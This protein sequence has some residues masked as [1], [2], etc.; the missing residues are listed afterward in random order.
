MVRVVEVVVPLVEG[1]HAIVW[2]SAQ[3]LHFE[4][5]LVHEDHV[6]GT[7]QKVQYVAPHVGLGEGTGSG[8]CQKTVVMFSCVMMKR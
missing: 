1:F 4:F 5:V 7:G 2:I 6:E 8:S 3:M